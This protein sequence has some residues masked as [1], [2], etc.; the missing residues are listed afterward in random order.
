MSAF[1]VREGDFHADLETTRTQ[2]SF[3][4]HVLSVGHA[5]DED[6]VE[7]VDTIHLIEMVSE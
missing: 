4:Y 1:F 7:L 3:I 5:D 6:I 2:K